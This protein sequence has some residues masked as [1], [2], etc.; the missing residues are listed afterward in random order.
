VHGFSEVVDLAFVQAH[1]FAADNAWNGS[2][3]VSHI[4]PKKVCRASPL[5]CLA[6]RTIAGDT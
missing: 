4:T 5:R 3:A 1:R 2:E 6:Y